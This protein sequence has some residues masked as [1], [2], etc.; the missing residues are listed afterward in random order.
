MTTTRLWDRA[1]LPVPT[2]GRRFPEVAS[3]PTDL[4]TVPELFDFMRDA[5]LRFGTLRM[6]ILERVANARGDDEVEIYVVLRHPGQAKVTTSRPGELLVSYVVNSMN[7]GESAN[8]AAVYRPRF[9]RVP[10]SLLPPP[11]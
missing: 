2:D 9:I 11:E 8:N 3:L 5:E 10:V 4:P 7:F 6:R 1:A